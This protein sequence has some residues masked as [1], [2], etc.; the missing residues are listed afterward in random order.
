MSGVFSSRINNFLLPRRHILIEPEL[1]MFRPVLTS[2]ANS[3]PCYTLLSRQL[4]KEREWDT[5]FD[6]YLPEQRLS[7]E[8][9]K[10]ALLPRN[11]TLL[12]VANPP[13][14]NVAS[15]HNTPGRWWAALMD[16]CLRQSDINKYGSV[17]VI[18]TM[19]TEEV[20]TILPRQL[21]ERRRLSFLTENVALHAFDVAC[22]KHPKSWTSLKLWSSLNRDFERAEARREASGITT[23]AGR[24]A[25]KL[26]PAP[27]SPALRNK[28]IKKP[29]DNYQ[30]RV[31][32]EAHTRWT[33]EMDDLTKR[34]KIIGQNHE[35]TKTVKKKI[36]R[37]YSSFRAENKLCFNRQ[38]II[39]QRLELDRKTQALSRAAADLGK[40]AADLQALDDEIGLMTRKYH[41]EKSEVHFK[42]AAVLERFVDDELVEQTSS[43]PILAWGQ[44]PFN[45]LT[46]DEGDVWPYEPRSVI[47]FEADTNSIARQYLERVPKNQRQQLLDLFDA[48][49]F[50]G[51]RAPLTVQEL[52]HAIFPGRSANDLVRAIPGVAHLAGK[53]LKPGAGP[54]PL[55]DP[56]ADPAKSFQE[57]IDYDL[58]NVRIRA[59]PINVIWDILLEYQSHAPDLSAIQFSRKLGGTM[60]FYR[61]GELPLKLN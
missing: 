16:S 53:R 8:P 45:P 18:A 56:S 28:K 35:E 20:E 2:L 23:P 29:E 44:R 61:D 19:P 32:T 6:Q 13:Y 34:L 60:T 54:V 17:R 43:K 9:G 30:P 57:N 11:D 49:T 48:L 27:E 31:W 4:Y 41:E 7:D 36:S 14:L 40:T 3:K 47:Y 59:L 38:K 1:D 12:I 58:S 46:L 52:S 55:S 15:D 5:I 37:I 21:A 10:E 39:D 25:P 24:E 51:T 33:N 26:V 50:S 22:T 42:K